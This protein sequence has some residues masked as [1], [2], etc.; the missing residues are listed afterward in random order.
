ME[1]GSVRKILERLIRGDFD[2]DEAVRQI[3]RQQEAREREKRHAY[4]Q[5]LSIA[6]LRLGIP[7]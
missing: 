1:Q 2:I 3:E 7:K 4:E 6:K 5:A